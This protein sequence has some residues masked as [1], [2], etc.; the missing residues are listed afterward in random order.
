MCI[1]DRVKQ[2]ADVKPEVLNVGVRKRKHEGAEEEEEAGEAVVRRGWGSTTREYPGNLASVEDIGALLKKEEPEVKSNPVEETVPG[3]KN[4]ESVD[5]LS[6][7]TARE[8]VSTSTDA[9]IK[10]DPD[11]EAAAPVFFKKRKGKA[12][13][14]G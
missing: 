2:E 12:L 4:E 9:T 1:R 6:P 11:A 5:H 10:P 8:T 13:K 7:S 14:A 3:I